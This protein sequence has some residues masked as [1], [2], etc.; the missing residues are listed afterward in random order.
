MDEK[1][2]EKNYTQKDSIFV[3]QYKAYL[4]F[5][6]DLGSRRQRSNEFF[7]TVSTALIATIGLSWGSGNSKVFLIY[8][9]CLVG[10]LLSY[11]W[12]RSLKSYRVIYYHKYRIL[13]EMEK[14]LPACPITTELEAA[15]RIVGQK[16]GW[17]NFKTSSYFETKIPHI[18]SLFFLLIFFLRLLL[19][20][21]II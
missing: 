7:M 15:D 11:I 8:I 1:K 21:K 2:E 4:A 12:A 17:K 20:L 13:K 16:D 6:V 19:D 3:E 5:L 10:I 9:A 18:F 14:D